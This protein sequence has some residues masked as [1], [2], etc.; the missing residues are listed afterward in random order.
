[1]K[2]LKLIFAL[3]LMM[4]SLGAQTAKAAPT[5]D[6]SD[7]KDLLEMYLD[8]APMAAMVM[9]Y[10]EQA[11]L[12]QILEDAQA[13]YDN[14]AATL[15]EVNAEIAKLDAIAV[16]HGQAIFDLYHNITLTELDGLAMEDDSEECQ[17]IIADAKA[18]VNA[19]SWT[20]DTEKSFVENTGSVMAVLTIIED[21]KAALKEERSAVVYTVF[22]ETTNTLTYYFNNQYD[23]TNK[24]HILYDPND[25][26]RLSKST[27]DAIYTV[28]IDESMKKAK[29]KSMRNMFSG[30]RSIVEGLPTIE[31]YF[32][33]LES[34]IGIEN[35]NT[36]NVTNMSQMFKGCKSLQSLDLSHFDTENVTKMR[37]MFEG[38]K[39]L[40]SLDLTH[41]DTRNVEDMSAMFNQCESLETID[42]TGFKTDNLKD[43]TSMF[44]NCEHLRTI[45]CEGDWSQSSTLTSYESIFF[46]CYYLGGER[47]TT[48]DEEQAIYY[49]EEE[50]KWYEKYDI[51]YARVD[52]G[53][54]APGF[55]TKKFIPDP[56]VPEEIAAAK[57]ELEQW[58]FAISMVYQLYDMTG[59]ADGFAEM[60]ALL[61]DAS[62]IDDKADATLEEINAQIATLKEA[63]N[64]HKAEIVL[65]YQILGAEE[66]D[67]LLVE[68][69]SEECQKIIADAKDALNAALVWNDEISYIENIDA[70]AEAFGLIYDQ[71]VL[72]LAAQRGSEHATGIEKGE[73]QE[74]KGESRKFFR[75]GV[76]YIEHEGKTYNILGA[77][78]R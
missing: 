12:Q 38:C 14:P 60:E 29:L 10:S 72:D 9:S 68:G 56:E 64:A 28:V 11:E 4:L 74:A 61:V 24:N 48:Y 49:D 70:L 54:E 34:I 45:Y 16:S 58:M 73:W 63:A 21:T 50:E 41:F 75:N 39:S 77:E 42:L 17:K 15:D 46:N 6:I 19:L 5:D 43:V 13:V 25:D 51:T 44:Q 55:F 33:N 76:L 8:M 7:A 3:G 67:A 2:K 36:E 26:Y 78:A 53:E 35:L 57:Q 37:Q 52:G 20:Y 18:Q 47:G 23:A 30:G 32:A 59:D 1:M 69:D 22:D 71:A 62:E 31:C 65:Y 27:A 40:Q 66:L